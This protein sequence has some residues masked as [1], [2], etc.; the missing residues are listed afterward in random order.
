MSRVDDVIVTLIKKEGGYVDHPS[1]RG[2]PTMY[3]ITETTARANGY[4]GDMRFLPKSLAEIIYLNKYWSKP[5][6]GL[7][8]KVSEKIAYELFDTGVNMGPGIPCIWFQQWL[9]GFNRK[10]QDYRD[11]TV[12]G[13]IGPVT[14]VALQKFLSIR[15]AEGE[16]VFLG[17]LNCSQGERYRELAESREAN[18]DFLYGWILQRVVKT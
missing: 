2:G 10:Q 1:D 3:G 8:N 6:F 14:I 18:E 9:N 15:G 17:A 7:I 13:H 4:K 11:L 12:D 5:G 16:M